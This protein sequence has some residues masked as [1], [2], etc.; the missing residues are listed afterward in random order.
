MA[1][2]KEMRMIRWMTD[3]SELRQRE[4][5]RERVGVDDIMI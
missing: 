3:V 2:R 1:V 5:E 4:R